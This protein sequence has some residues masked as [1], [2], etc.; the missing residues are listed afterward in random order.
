MIKNLYDSVKN[1]TEETLSKKLQNVTNL[2]ESLAID[3]VNDLSFGNYINL[4]KAIDAE[5]VSKIQGILDEAGLPNKVEVTNVTN[6]E[7]SYQ[8]DKG[9]TTTVDL[10]KPDVET[11]LKTLDQTGNQLAKDPAGDSTAPNIGDIEKGD[12]FGLGLEEDLQRIRELAGLQETSSSP[13]FISSVELNN[14]QIVDD[15]TVEYYYEPEEASTHNYP[16]AAAEAHIEAISYNGKDIDIDTVVN[17]DQL[18]DEALEAADQAG[19]DEYDARGDYD[20]ERQRERNYY[21][22]VV[23]ESQQLTEAAFLIP[24]IAT[25]I[26]LGGPALM[27]LISSNAVKQGTKQIAKGALKGTKAIGKVAAKGSKEL[28]KAA[29]KNPGKAAVVGTGAAYHEEISDIVDAVGVASDYVFDSIEE[30]TN[31]IENFDVES[32]II[33]PLAL[34]AKNFA[35]PAAAIIA[36]IYGGKMLWDYVS[37]DTNDETDRIRELAGV[38]ETAG[39]MGSGG[40]SVG[41]GTVTAATRKSNS[42]PGT[43]VGSEAYLNEPKK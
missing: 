33:A 35:L 9:S 5:D 10:R 41:G 19:Q 32:S 42:H 38:D 34:A 43:T 24:A 39:G 16:G 14:G 22:E 20:M 23:K 28:G 7:L 6:N 21:E 13:T 11:D 12:E 3:L 29:L 25:A 4:G 26:R 37:D 31:F 36:I 2:S 8:D 15:V 1:I 40:M 27:R 18:T 30:V 17:I